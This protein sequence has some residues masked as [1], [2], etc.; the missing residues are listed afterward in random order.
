MWI[1]RFRP[2]PEVARRLGAAALALA[3]L[4]VAA[5]ADGTNADMPSG[6]DA[7][8]DA[9]PLMGIGT[10]PGFT[11]W[12]TEPTVFNDAPVT[13]TRD[14]D[15]C[16]GCPDGTRQ[17][18]GFTGGSYGF[19]ADGDRETDA[20]LTADV[21]LVSEVQPL[22]DGAFEYRWSVNNLGTGAVVGVDCG[23]NGPSLAVSS[24]DPLLGTSGADRLPDTGDD[25]SAGATLEATRTS[26][27][28]AGTVLCA[29]TFN[30]TTAR[31]AR[32]IVP[33]P[34]SPASKA[35][36]K[37]GGWMDFGFRN[38]G[39]CIRMVNTGRDSRTGANG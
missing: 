2:T 1:E 38:Q 10:T 3:V 6:P 23:P 4:L 31:A 14:V 8:P 37:D 13:F 5:C 30:P 20:M 15:T 22:D 36:C 32:L 25:V 24:S 28:A 19:D 33:L 16:P 26:T 7:G 35:H 12:T 39:R 34:A 9:A 29:M 27:I 17:R 18:S 21:E 11:D